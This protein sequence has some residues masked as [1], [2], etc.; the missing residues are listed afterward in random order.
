LSTLANSATQQRPPAASVLIVGVGALGCAAAHA[1]AAHGGTDLTVVDDDNVELSNLQRQVL[2]GDGDVGRPKAATAAARLR[3]EFPNL[4]I[5]A[6]QTRLDDDNALELFESHDYVVDGTDN[7]TSKFLI[8]KVG[9]STST[10]FC[11]AGVE[12]TQGQ[13]LAVSPGETACLACLFP[14]Q[15][16]DDNGGCAALG[17]LAPVAGV[18]GALQAG[19]AAAALDLGDG[20]SPGHLISYDAGTAGWR[21]VKLQRAL[22]CPVCGTSIQRTKTGR[23]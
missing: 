22:D 16:V 12:R 9:I 5:S 17:I 4:R 1:L 3:S 23:A 20:P 13:L 21:Q 19:A 8:N 11:Y 10:P 18:V 7:P 14:D 15:E 2:Y 6:T